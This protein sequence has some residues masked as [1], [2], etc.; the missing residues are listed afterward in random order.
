MTI[1]V[2]DNVS[3]TEN[4][5]LEEEFVLVH[6]FNATFQKKED[7]WGGRVLAGKDSH[8]FDGHGLKFWDKVTI[9]T[10]FSL[11]EDRDLRDSWLVKELVD[12][13]LQMGGEDIEELV[14]LVLFTH[15]YDIGVG[16]KEKLDTLG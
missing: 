16:C 12:I 9:E 13:G 2:H 4:G 5:A 3:L 8:T 10:H 7:F 6:R 14:K 11:G 1:S 15:G